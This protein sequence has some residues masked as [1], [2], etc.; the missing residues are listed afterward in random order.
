MIN[1]N[2]SVRD[3]YVINTGEFHDILAGTPCLIVQDKE[4]SKDGEHCSYDIVEGSPLMPVEDD[5][6]DEDDNEDYEDD[7]PQPIAVAVAVAPVAPFSSYGGKKYFS[8]NSKVILPFS[9]NGSNINRKKIA[10]SGAGTF[11]AMVD[12]SKKETSLLDRAS[13][14]ELAPMPDNQINKDGH[15]S[16]KIIELFDI[17]NIVINNELMSVTSIDIEN[18]GGSVCKLIESLIKTFPHVFT[19]FC[20]TKKPAVRKKGKIEYDLRLAVTISNVANHMP[21][22]EQFNGVFLHVCIIDMART[23]LMSGLETMFETTL[24]FSDLESAAF[25]DGDRILHSTDIKSMCNYIVKNIR[26]LKTLG[27]H[28]K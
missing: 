15:L 17:N 23:K 9:T 12:A 16:N 7:E 24:L 5:E 14:I 11:A 19:L 28:T 3:G 20:K 1:G 22:L 18:V 2:K 10:M 25:V 27:R 4:E 6:Y 21:M 13:L 26:S 8:K